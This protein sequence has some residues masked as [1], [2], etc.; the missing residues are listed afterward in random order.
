M[1][2]ELEI[3]VTADT[4]Q[5]EQALGRFEQRLDGIANSASP[6]ARAVEQLEEKI[7]KSELS[8]KRQEEAVTGSS[9]SLVAMALRVV[10]GPTAIATALAYGARKAVDFADSIDDVAKSSKMG[11]DAVQTLG[12]IAS[13]NAASFDQIATAST[14]LGR[15]LSSGMPAA[16]Q[17]MQSLGLS[18]DALLAMKPEDRFR[19]VGIAIAGVK[20][21]ARQAE[22]AF[23]ATGRG[24]K[25][26]LG[27]FADLRDGAEK[28]APKMSSAYV[29]AGAAVS[30]AIDLMIAKGKTWLA[31]MA[32]FPV[33]AAREMG[34]M[35]GE[36]K[37]SFS[38]VGMFSGVTGPGGFLNFRNRMMGGGFSA[39][40]PNG[41]ATPKPGGVYGPELPDGWW[42]IENHR[43]AN[44]EARRKRQA[45]LARAPFVRPELMGETDW[46]QYSLLQ[47][48]WY[49]AAGRI[50]GIGP[51]SFPGWAPFSGTREG[52]LPMVSYADMSVP[53]NRPNV[54]RGSW[55][56]GAGG[57]F[58]GAGLS[59]AASFIP[60][61]NNQGSMIGSS[62]GS[63][64]GSI[65]GVAG[66]L[67]SFAP[68]LG[69]IAGIAGGLI[70]KLFSGGEG[71]QTK[72]ERDSFIDDFG[73][74]DELQKVADKVGFS[75]DKML[76]TKKVADFQA[77]VTRLEQ[78]M[79]AFDA[80]VNAANEE[81]ATMK[82]QLADTQGELDGVL[83]KASD[84][85]YNFD[86]SG[87]LV[88]VNFQK[89]KEV[90]DK[91]KISIDQLGPAFQQQRLSDMAKEIIN[92]FTL[93]NLG[94][95][96]TGTI[97]EGMSP[98]INELVNQS[99]KYGTE[100]PANMKPWIEDLI[101]TGKLTDENGTK[102]T[103]LS[104]IKFGEPVA[105]EYEKIQ[106]A[107]KELIAKMGDLITKIA[108]MTTKIDEMTRPRT[109]DIGFNV[110][111][112]PDLSELD[113]YTEQMSRGGVVPFPKYLSAGGFIPRGTD[114]VPAMLTPGEGVLRREAVSRLMRGDWPQ[115]GGGLSV[116]IDSITVGTFD[117]EADAET[118]L[119]RALV[120]GLKRRGV[121]L[122][123]A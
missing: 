38:L 93:L 55:L 63:A 106:G 95:T 45:E 15:R 52:G 92:D 5:A 119:G 103:D 27:V 16:V 75:L 70:G 4:S 32:L 86:K 42:A 100:I 64:L 14:E 66:A 72:K 78:A 82:G 114:T 6:A 113:G 90:A 44:E 84:M 101:R 59:A 33:V 97:L 34:K 96:Q 67:G 116:S 53:M 8:F 79:G 57:R 112:M 99:V 19:A 88:S 46:T 123:A 21:P 40:D 107:V 94:G 18:V 13:K 29:E 51:T 121:R 110:A 60:G 68:F 10:G 83:S 120:K 115:G 89:M 26:L 62:F 105:T 71:K 65:K 91:Y 118:K 25:E 23:D 12:F 2:R 31:Q 24:G 36:V 109:V 69:P 117:S 108:D 111:P 61:M 1:A 30:D 54:S 56:Q 28:H 22:L 43:L 80:K 11:S 9:Q 102:V 76:S 20:D 49:N 3:A 41:A 48:G 37:E 77:E 81:L 104:K 7:S 73:G 50:P 39:A 87:N 122:Q 35:A 17:A 58:L 74:M 98:K 85:G 47:A